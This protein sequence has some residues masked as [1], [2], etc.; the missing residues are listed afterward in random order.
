MKLRAILVTIHIVVV[1]RVEKR[2][3]HKVMSAKNYSVTVK[4]NCTFLCEEEGIIF[5]N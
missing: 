5:Q 1:S 3:S 2:V 4:E